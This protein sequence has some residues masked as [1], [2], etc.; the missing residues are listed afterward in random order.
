MKF[1]SIFLIVSCFFNFTKQNEERDYSEEIFDEIIGK[2]ITHYEQIN[3]LQNTTDLT[4]LMFLYKRSSMK[5]RIIANYLINISKQ[6]Q[7]LAEILLIDCQNFTSFPK[8]NICEENSEK[9]S[10]PKMKLLVPNQFKI[11]PYTGGIMPHKE[12]SFNE[13]IVS[14]NSIYNFITKNIPSFSV[15]LSDED[16]DGFVSDNFMLNKIILFTD[17]NTTPVMF[18][19]L[20]CYFYDQAEFAVA[21]KSQSD[22]IQF[23]NIT[24]FPTIVALRTF[25]KDIHLDK[26]IYY[27]YDGAINIL[28]IKSFIEKMIYPIKRYLLESKGRLTQNRTL[29]DIFTPLDQNNIDIFKEINQ[30]KMIALYFDKNYKVSVEAERFARETQ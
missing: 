11:N 12:V 20:S 17:K 8:I 29:N 2:N 28:E 6:L 18:R 27:T 30:N 21:N 14:E 9:D 13:T 16:F 23:F 24:K 22:M 5:S 7:Y 15:Q 19:G 10:F 25:D 26:T 3:N 4:Y 1:I